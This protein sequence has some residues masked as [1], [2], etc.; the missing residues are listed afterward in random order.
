LRDSHTPDSFRL[1]P[2]NVPSGTITPANLE[3]E[4]TAVRRLRPPEGVSV[5]L[6][7]YRPEGFTFRA[8]HFDVEHAYG[9]W[10]AR[11]E[12]WNELF[13][14]MEQWDVVAKSHNEVVL[15]CC[16]ARDFLQNEWQVIALYD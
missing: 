13:W 2:F 5:R 14:N 16:I 11:G 1:E 6:G 12:W 9:P 7:R 3:G 8:Q 15:C 4:R 10:A